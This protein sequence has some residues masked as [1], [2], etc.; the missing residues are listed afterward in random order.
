MSS[1]FERSYSRFFQRDK[2][3]GNTK[4]QKKKQKNAQEIFL[5]AR[6]AQLEKL[7]PAKSQDH[8]SDES[9]EE[10]KYET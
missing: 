7:I 10:I 1:K 3:T 4:S 8:F 5:Q 2:L 6:I 9:E